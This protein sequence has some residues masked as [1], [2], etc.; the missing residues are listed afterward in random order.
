MST[1]NTEGRTGSSPEGGRRPHNT[2]ELLAGHLIG[3]FR[4]RV[5][6]LTLTTAGR[7]LQEAGV[8]TLLKSITDDGWVTSA[9]PV[10]TLEHA[11]D[12][13]ILSDANSTDLT[14]RIID[15]NH[16]VAALKRL[17]E[18]NATDSIIDVQVH[19]A[20]GERAERIIATS[21]RRWPPEPHSPVVP[22]FA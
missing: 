4:A 15:G 21:E 7:A 11:A 19:R 6:K 14:F 13:G 5:S 2:A 12:E 10:V 17:D 20:L 22:K 16:R 18:K 3:T 9:T 8:D 1:T